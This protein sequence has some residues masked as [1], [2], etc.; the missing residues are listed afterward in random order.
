[1]TAHKAHLCYCGETDPANFYG[2]TKS[3]CKRCK[4]EKQTGKPYKARGTKYQHGYMDFQMRMLTTTDKRIA[5]MR[6]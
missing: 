5:R 2:K 3:E 4:N 6:W 1:M